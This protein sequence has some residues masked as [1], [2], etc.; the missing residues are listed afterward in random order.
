MSNDNTRV[1]RDLL[2]ADYNGIDQRLTRRLGSADLAAD[3]LQETYLR[4]EGLT[5]VEAI[6]S[7]KAYLFRI[8]LNIANDHRRA[9]SRNLTSGEV[10]GLLDIPDD[11]PT[12]EREI[13]ERSEITLLQRVIAELPERR[14]Q[15]L[16]MSRIENLPHR[17]IAQ[18]IG[19][20]VRTVETDLK[21]AIEHCVHR[22][23]RNVPVKFGFAR[24][25]TSTIQRRVVR[26][27]LLA[28]GVCTRASDRD[29]TN[30]SIP[31]AGPAGPRGSV[32]GR[33]P[34]VRRGHAR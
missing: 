33:A 25:E 11:R 1:L 21:Q 17:E 18:R 14:R 5:E 9:Q 15:V 3:V 28:P 34:E 6:R 4:I 19:V 24:R 12:P 30:R 26:D 7:P 16:I 2:L 31:T 13:E 23:K 32:V 27:E 22:L 20:T 29:E 8:A 10:D